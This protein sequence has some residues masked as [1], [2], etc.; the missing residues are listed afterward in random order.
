MERGQR[1]SIDHEGKRN[2]QTFSPAGLFAPIFRENDWNDYRIVA[3]GERVNVFV[4]G[5]LFSELI[6]QED[7]AKD[8]SG[9]LAFQLHSGPET[10]V[11]FRNIV[12]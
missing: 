7:N 3:V 4:N 9:K 12:L 2:T 8:L 6:D 5:T 10:R 11:A 1:V